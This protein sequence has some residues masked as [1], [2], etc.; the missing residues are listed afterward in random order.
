MTTLS[1]DS[2]ELR[3]VLD[4]L[5]NEEE[6]R[7]LCADLQVDY[8]SLPGSGKAAKARE[9]VGY[10]E[11]QGRVQELMT[12]VKKE[13]RNAFPDADKRGKY[14]IASGKPGGSV[15]ER[16]HVNDI[17]GNSLELAEDF[18]QADFIIV[19]LDNPPPNWLKYL[20]EA[21][22]PYSDVVF[23]TFDTD[24]PSRD[25]IELDGKNI[26]EIFKRSYREDQILV[27]KG[28]GELSGALKH[29]AR[30]LKMFKDSNRL[31]THA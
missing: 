4:E 30:T 1:S 27:C 11:R 3:R 12:F 28:P 23:V 26:L 24:L 15:A 9:L 6:L 18:N 21:Q 19:D 20:V 16:L 8:D 25:P 7:N 22:Q 5:F 13:R 17:V 14:Y 2:S 10:F 29:I 31:A